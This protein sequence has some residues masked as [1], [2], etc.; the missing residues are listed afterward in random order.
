MNLWRSRHANS[1]F[2]PLL[3]FLFHETPVRLSKTTILKMVF[4]SKY[5]TGKNVSELWAQNKCLWH[6]AVH[7]FLLLWKRNSS[8]PL[9][10]KWLVAFSISRHGCQMFCHCYWMKAF[11]C[12]KEHPLHQ[13]Q[14]SG[15]FF[16]DLLSRRIVLSLLNRN[17]LDF[18]RKVLKRLIKLWLEILLF[19]K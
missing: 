2:H 7:L 1:G 8:F 9:L 13:A 14:G 12:C 18:H 4:P 11:S 3:P 19:F 10:E 6:L 17:L 15:S 16:Q 5:L